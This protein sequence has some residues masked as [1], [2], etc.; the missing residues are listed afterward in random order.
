MDKFAK[1]IAELDYYKLPDIV[2]L[3][4]LYNEGKLDTLLNQKLQ[5]H[6]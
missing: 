1:L 4:Q 5:E 3:L 6:E 2:L